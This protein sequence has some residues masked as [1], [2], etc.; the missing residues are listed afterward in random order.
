VSPLL[1][2]LRPPAYLALDISASH[3]ATACAD[4]QR[5]HP[6]LPVLGICC[7]Y[8]RLEALPAHPRLKGQ[9]RL[10]FYPGSSIGNFEPAEALALLQRFRRLL[11]PQSALLVGVDHPK[12]VKRL[13]A[14]YNDAA[15]VSAAF[16]LNLL[17]RL[18]RDLEGNF[19][20]E[21]FRYQARWESGASR[22]VME[23]VSRGEQ[24][25]RLAGA[26][27][28]FAAGEALVTEHSHKYTAAAFDSLA[29]R[30]GWHPRQAWSDPL[31]D[32]SLRLLVPAAAA[33][34]DSGEAQ[35][36]E[37]RP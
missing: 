22:I 27:W 24:T 30:A 35:A 2:A 16:A 29:E 31:G 37:P 20:P 33:Q 6:D 26:S 25:V 23:L 21:A 4:L 8:A 28:P 3:L 12:S 19:D 13:K 1:D 9:R 15:G 11:G 10:G 18:N 36:G 34:A 14:A 17:H 32:L 5:R 7:D